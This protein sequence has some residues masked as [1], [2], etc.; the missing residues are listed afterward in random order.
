MGDLLRARLEAIDS[1]AIAAVRGRGL[2]PSRLQAR[3]RRPSLPPHP[4]PTRLACRRGLLNAVVV[5]PDGANDAGA[6][7]HALMGAGLLAKPT[8][9]DIIRLAPPLVISEEQ[10]MQ[11]ADI[12]EREARNSRRVGGGQGLY[13]RSKRLP[14]AE[15]GIEGPP[16]AAWRERLSIL[17]GPL[18]AGEA[19]LEAR[20]QASVALFKLGAHSATL[21]PEFG[22]PC[23]MSQEREIFSVCVMS[24]EI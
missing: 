24:H 10:V 3:L 19:L 4:C 21:R 18:C 8:H 17:R 20:T 16:Q 9:G 13:L 2:S 22:G 7:C 12:I 6:L 11:A 15:L 23:R 1:P 5:R 14:Q